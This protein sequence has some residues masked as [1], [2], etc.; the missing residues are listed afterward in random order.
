MQQSTVSRTAGT[1]GLSA[2]WHELQQESTSTLL[3][4]H[5]C[6]RVR[7][8]NASLHLRNGTRHC[9]RQRCDL[10][11]HMRLSTMHRS[12]SQRRVKQDCRTCTDKDCARRYWPDCK[13]HACQQDAAT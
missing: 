5:C 2:L 10:A 9:R 3:V 6:Q 7:H 1:H 12:C 4:A 8:G 13:H 11:K